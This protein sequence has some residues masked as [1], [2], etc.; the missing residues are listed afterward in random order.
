MSK[1]PRILHLHSTFDAGGK[2][3]RNVRLINEWGKQ[4]D[5]AIVS[6]DLEKRGAPAM[7]SPGPRGLE[8]IFGGGAIEPLESDAIVQTRSGPAFNIVLSLVKHL[9]GGSKRKLRG[10]APWARCLHSSKPRG[11]GWL[12]YSCSACREGLAPDS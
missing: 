7:P 8:A 10:A 5:H 6:G 2:E 12:L 11:S 3:L 9:D 4:V 1:T